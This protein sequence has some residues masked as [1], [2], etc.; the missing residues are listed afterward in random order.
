MIAKK[1]AAKKRRL[2]KKN[3]KIHSQESSQ[4]ST[5]Q[6]DSIQHVQ[7][8]EELSV[9]TSESKK[10]RGRPRKDDV[11]VTDDTGE[12]SQSKSKKKGKNKRI[13]IVDF[14][15]PSEP[16]SVNVLTTHVIIINVLVI[17]SKFILFIFSLTEKT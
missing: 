11:H 15:G 14:G 7:P 4:K 2:A 9:D 13:E 1:Q 6:Q 12:P 16:K 10:K 5:H 3:Q 8:Y 17:I